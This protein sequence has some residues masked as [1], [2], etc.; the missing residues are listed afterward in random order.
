IIRFN[1]KV[2]ARMPEVVAG[3][4]EAA[5]DGAAGPG[6]LSPQLIRD[7]YRDSTQEQGVH[8]GEGGRVEIVFRIKEKGETKDDLLE[9]LGRELPLAVD[10][11][12]LNKGY[13]Q[14]DILFLVRKNSEGEMIGKMLTNYKTR[15]DGSPVEG[16]AVVSADIFRIGS[17]PAIRRV[18][19]ALNILVD[20]DNP[21]HG[22]LLSWELTDHDPDGWGI[23]PDAIHPLVTALIGQA[24]SL[25]RL[26]LTVM[27]DHLINLLGQAMEDSD[28]PYLLQFRDMVGRFGRSGQ[29]HAAGFLEWWERSGHK[30]ML[31][32]ESR[33]N[34]MKIMTIHKAK[35]LSSPVVILPFCNW[36][37]DHNSLKAP[38]LWVST[39]QPPFD[40]APVLP[41]VYTEKMKE[42]WF[43]DFYLQ[44]WI[45]T[46]L[47]NLNLL[48][49]S[50]TRPKD[51][52]LAFC[53]LAEKS[54]TVANALHEV[55]SRELDEQG[56]FLTGDQGQRKK[57]TA[58]LTTHE[59]VDP[60]VIGL[61]RGTFPVEPRQVVAEEA[62]LT[63]EMV[64]RLLE[65]MVTVGDLERSILEIAQDETF[66][67]LDVSAARQQVE[68]IFDIPEV[69]RWFDGSGRVLTE[70]SILIPGRPE[71]RPDRIVIRDG[72]AEVIDYKTGKPER[73]HHR[74]VAEYMD[75]IG[76]LGFD[77]VRGFILYI[78]Q[79]ELVEVVKGQE[80]P[81]PHFLPDPTG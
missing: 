13:R 77:P 49:V 80:G 2:F 5:Q 38:Y 66:A 27:V 23:D 74:Q 29:G 10:D 41:V 59:M 32:T 71:R 15:A 79:K 40:Q 65:S 39:T 72:A 63:G 18:L 45:D 70:R 51:V 43:S 14:E 21:L 3:Y 4:Y 56:R 73:P 26:D 6:Q 76:H 16:W 36:D 60:G 1:N 78:D 22:K 48:Y 17:N 11:L 31:V 64:H 62:R 35:G 24:D 57:A 12:L 52:L 9:W 68:A 50:F 42:T 61:G 37:L 44:E 20:P 47:D 81:S 67:G 69:L 7:A 46:H 53:P 34:A 33:P 55:L 28:Q 8:S 19:L 54:E 25:S 75:L 30:K 58:I